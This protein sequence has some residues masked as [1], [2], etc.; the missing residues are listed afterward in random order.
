MKSARSLL[1]ALLLV[2]ATGTPLVAASLVAGVAVSRA[3][4]SLP[5]SVL[6]VWRGPECPAPEGEAARL[7]LKMCLYDEY[8]F[9]SGAAGGQLARQYPEALSQRLD[10][11]THDV[12]GPTRFEKTMPAGELMAVVAM[13]TQTLARVDLTGLVK[14]GRL[15]WDASSGAWKIMAFTCVRDG[16][17]AGIGSDGSCAGA[18]N[19]KSLRNGTSRQKA[20]RQSILVEA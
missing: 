9:P 2:S 17:R 16:A 20:L 6:V 10:L 3:Q 1:A 5:C 12:A 8:W 18:K 11:V 13:N 7:G 15:I 19:G 14:D 4:P